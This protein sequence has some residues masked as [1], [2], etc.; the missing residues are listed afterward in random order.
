MITSLFTKKTFNSYFIKC[1]FVIEF[2]NNFTTNIET[3]YVHNVESKKTKSYLLYYIDCF[4]ATGYN[5]CNINQM[6]F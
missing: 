2:D 5:V 6:T 4:T 3:N 1:D